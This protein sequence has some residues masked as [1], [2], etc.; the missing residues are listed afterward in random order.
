MLHFLGFVVFAVVFLLLFD[1]AE[2]LFAKLISFVY[3]KLG[4]KDKEQGS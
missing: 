1:L 3:D 2:F 4:K